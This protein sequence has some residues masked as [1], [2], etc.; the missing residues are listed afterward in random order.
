MHPLK[1]LIHMLNIPAGLVSLDPLF[2]FEAANQKM[3]K[4]FLNRSEENLNAEDFVE[5]EKKISSIH[6]QSVNDKYYPYC[7]KTNSVIEN[8]STL[9]LMVPVYGDSNRKSIFIFAYPSEFVFE[10]EGVLH[11]ASICHDINNPL[12]IL[13]LTTSKIEKKQQLEQDDIDHFLKII[14]DVTTRINEIMK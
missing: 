9:L 6:S 1:A 14:K 11:D 7:I 13:M 2:K 3:M 4:Q 5:I 10:K 8:K 12:A